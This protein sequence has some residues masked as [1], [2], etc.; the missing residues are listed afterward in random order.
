MD[1]KLRCQSCGMPIREDYFG[2]NADGS[3][4]QEYCKF[5]WQNGHFTNPNQT[6]DQMVELS[7]EKYDSGIRNAGE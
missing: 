5:C 3:D 2:T 1:Q 7:V 4:S 6:L